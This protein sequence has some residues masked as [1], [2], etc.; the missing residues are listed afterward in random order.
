[1]SDVTS[2]IRAFNRFYTRQIGLLDEHIVESP[3]TLSEA[4]V[5]YE[6]ATFGPLTAADLGR[7]LGLDRAY[8]SRML[9][10]FV[11]RGLLSA[12]SVD[13]DRRKSTLSLTTAGTTAV[14]AL[15]QGSDRIMANLLGPIAA[16]DRP[17]LLRAMREIR[18]ILGDQPTEP[19][20]L[21][22]HRIGELGWLI[23]R[24]A[25]LY[26]AQF[27][28]NSE[29]ESLIARIYHEHESAPGTPPKALWVADQGGSVMGSV[30]VTPRPGHE[31][32]AQL[33]MLYVEPA[34]RGQ[35]VGTRLV[36]EAV[37]FAA[38]AGYRRMRL[39]TQSVLVSARRIYA[40]AG[41]ACVE[42][43]PHHSFGQDLVGEY[44]ER[45]F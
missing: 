13:G 42:S 41:F 7:R 27:G 38:A 26:A 25:V 31:D 33:R 35:G 2:D 18:H 22:S 17:A 43:S 32:T 16:A 14:A 34:A 11:T 40:G 19:I 24:Q 21:R 44:W 9:Q 12:K 1:M 45:E 10:S 15:N 6:I 23:H 5:L 39:W 8:L 28:W 36:A 3:F 29:F 4:R 30:F 20:V 37:A